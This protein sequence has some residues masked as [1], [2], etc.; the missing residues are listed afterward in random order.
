MQKSETCPAIERGLL[1]ET[2]ARKPG[3]CDLLHHLVD[4][5]AFVCG[6]LLP[7]FGDH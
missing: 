4:G 1:E 7:E 2:S 3:E 5:I 6:V